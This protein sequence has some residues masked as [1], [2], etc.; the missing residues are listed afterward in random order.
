MKRK[1]K[2]RQSQSQALPRVSLLTPTFNR[3]AFFGQCVRCVL[4]QDYP[5]D[6]VEWIIL[7]DGTDPIRDLLPSPA[8]TAKG[9]SR[10]GESG[11]PGLPRIRYVRLEERLPLG[12]KRNRLHAL[13]TGDI[14]MYVDDDD[15]YPPCR[16]SRSVQ[17]LVAHTSAMAAGC[18]EIPVWFLDDDVV[19]TFGPYRGGHASCGTLAFRRELVAGPG[20]RACIPS[21]AHAEEQ[22]LLDDWR[23]PL[24][25]MDPRDVIL[26]VAHGANTV[27]K[28][29]VRDSMMR[30]A[31]GIAYCRRSAVPGSKVVRDAASRAFYRE[32]RAGFP[33][34]AL[35]SPPAGFAPAA[36]AS[37]PAGFAPAALASPPTASRLPERCCGAE[38]GTER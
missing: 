10:A 30:R 3:R 15:Y 2:Q 9:S 26:C 13:A 17:A 28:R 5:R 6:L 21:A 29:S 35:A 1:H 34:A 37:P 31:D 18:S 24:V 12:E 8:G 19:W 33:P 11:E 23:V 27:D 25:Q 20:A 14:L 4:H 22:H 16:V 38:C 32:L 7:D 36:L